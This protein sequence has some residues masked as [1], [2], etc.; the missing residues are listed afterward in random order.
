M[1]RTILCVLVFCSCRDENRFKF[2]Q[3]VA[4]VDSIFN[5]IDTATLI[6]EKIISPDS[7]PSNYGVIQREFFY[8]RPNRLILLIHQGEVDSLAVSFTGFF[9]DNELAMVETT[10]NKSDS[11]VY[12][13]KD[14]M[15]ASS[16]I[17]RVLIGERVIDS[18]RIKKMMREAGLIF[19]K[20]KAN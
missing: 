10:L 15:Y 11:C 16:I 12:Q 5:R 20:Q 9:I 13:L 8:E 6:K 3:R 2:D 1:I 18:E 17:H 4:F 19:I 14:Y 7:F